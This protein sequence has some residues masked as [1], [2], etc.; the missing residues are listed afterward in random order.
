MWLT[1][2]SVC[3]PRSSRAIQRHVLETR[4]LH[5]EGTTFDVAADV[6]YGACAQYIRGFTGLFVLQLNVHHL[7]GYLTTLKQLLIAFSSW[8]RGWYLSRI[9]NGGEAKV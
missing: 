4:A 5:F 7:F 2:V 3:L 6:A 9:L 8:M 1:I